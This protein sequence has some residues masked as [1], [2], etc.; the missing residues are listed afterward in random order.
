VRPN[1]R[2]R[3]CQR[4]HPPPSNSRLRT[5]RAL[6]PFRWALLRHNA[7]TVLHLGSNRCRE[8]AS[9]QQPIHGRG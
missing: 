9:T 7:P 2:R 3:H 5:P 8:E 1:R 6:P 4:I